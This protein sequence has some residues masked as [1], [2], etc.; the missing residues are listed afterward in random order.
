MRAKTSRNGATSGFAPFGP[1]EYNSAVVTGDPGFEGSET[2]SCWRAPLI[3]GSLAVMASAPARAQDIPLL[4][5]LLE[6]QLIQEMAEHDSE[7]T[8]WYNEKSV[9]KKKWT[10]GKLLGRKIRLASWTEQSKTWF[11][12]DDPDATLQLE[13]QRFAAR[14]ARL[15][16]A[17]VAN[18]KARYRVWG[19]IP[20]LIRASASGAARVKFEIAGSTAIGGGGLTDTQITTF[21]GKLTDLRFN[22]DLAHPFEDLVKDALND[23][24]KNKNAKMRRSIEKA[25]DRVRF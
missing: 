22:N 3:A 13:L 16:F 23:Y 4:R 7:E 21:K 18:A 2:M 20:K 17:L 12:L 15:E 9:D 8:A 6:Q 19:R 24:V 11:W 25:V 10:S 1:G 5:K 14:D